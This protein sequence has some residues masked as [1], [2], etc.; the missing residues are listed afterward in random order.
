M[1]APWK[2]KMSSLPRGDEVCSSALYGLLLPLF[3][4]VY[5]LMAIPMFL[6]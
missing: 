4:D 6:R 5:D 3:V 2:Q 1:E